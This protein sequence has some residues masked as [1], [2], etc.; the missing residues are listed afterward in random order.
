MAVHPTDALLWGN[1]SSLVLP[2][3]APSCRVNLLPSFS[4]AIPCFPN[5]SFSFFA[6]TH[7]HLCFVYPSCLLLAFKY[8]GETR[9]NKGHCFLVLT[10]RPHRQQKHCSHVDSNSWE[11]NRYVKW[12]HHI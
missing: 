12:P 1:T 5:L 8:E 10:V 7:L 11:M 6:F 9:W 2:T 4:L 3:S